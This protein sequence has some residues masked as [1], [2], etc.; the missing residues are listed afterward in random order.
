M[1]KGARHGRIGKACLK[2]E[3]A[4]YGRGLRAPRIRCL[5]V[6]Y[7]L[8]AQSDSPIIIVGASTEQGRRD[9]RHQPFLRRPRAATRVVGCCPE[10][11]WMHA[12][13]DFNNVEIPI[14]KARELLRDPS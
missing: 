10:V 7:G 9:D 5:N 2:V 8:L 14:T 4:S 3:D 13:T 6:P 11:D 1:T 12:R